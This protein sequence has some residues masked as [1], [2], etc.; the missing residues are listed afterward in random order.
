MKTTNFQS[1]LFKFGT[2]QHVYQDQLSINDNDM[3]GTKF[4]CMFLEF[5]KPQSSQYAL[6]VQVSLES[7]CI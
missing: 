1:N 4:D 6:T 5:S 2:I 7:N 3:Y